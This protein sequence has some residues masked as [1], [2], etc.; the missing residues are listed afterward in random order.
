MVP[1]YVT[2]CVAAQ[3]PK[4][5]IFQGFMEELDSVIRTESA[6]VGGLEQPTDAIGNQA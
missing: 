5:G 2:S 3:Y 1:V 6:N 4:T